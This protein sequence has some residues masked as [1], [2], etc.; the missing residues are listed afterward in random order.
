MLQGVS[1][2]KWTVNGAVV[3]V[4]DLTPVTGKQLRYSFAMTLVMKSKPIG[5]CAD[6]YD[7]PS[8]AHTP[9]ARRWNKL[10]FV[11][12]SSVHLETGDIEPLPMRNERP[13]HFSKVR[14]YGLGVVFEEDDAEQRVVGALQA[15]H[16]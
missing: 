16:V 6:T 4:Q 12:Y 7:I 11:E 1:L 5:R 15:L 13:F 8:L 9:A 3:Q 2:G 14:K 10:D